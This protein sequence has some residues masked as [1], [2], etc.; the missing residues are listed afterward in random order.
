MNISLSPPP[1]FLLLVCPLLFLLRLL[2]HLVLQWGEDKNVPGNARHL[3]KRRQR[4]RADNADEPWSFSFLSRVS[5]HLLS[6]P[7]SWHGEGC[8]QSSPLR[9][10]SPHVTT[11][12]LAPVRAVE[13]FRRHFSCWGGKV[14]AITSEAPGSLH[15]PI[16]SL[17]KGSKPGCEHPW[18]GVTAD[19]VRGGGEELSTMYPCVAPSVTVGLSSVRALILQ[20]KHFQPSS[21]ALTA[22]RCSSNSGHYLL[23]FSVS[24]GGRHCYDPSLTKLTPRHRELK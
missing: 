18:A 20:P 4:E 5:V 24:R 17:D 23:S 2:F 3:R 19:H 14:N 8:T 12:P 22:S 1:V 13:R 11:G 6:H 21:W 7:L 15:D 9:G 10:S 16:V